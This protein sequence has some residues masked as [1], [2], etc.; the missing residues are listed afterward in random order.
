MLN[1]RFLKKTVPFLFFFILLLAS[2]CE[3][4]ARQAKKLMNEKRNKNLFLSISADVMSLDPRYGAD[5]TSS[6]VIKMLFE[7]LM[8][9]D[10]D[11]KVSPAIAESFEV[12]PD[13]KSYLFTLRECQWSNGIDVTAYDFE[14]AWKSVVDLNN[15][16]A[17]MAAHNFFILK[18]VLKYRSQECDLDQIGVRALDA[19]TLKVELE[20]P[21]PYFLEA[22]TNTWFFP[23]CKMVDQNAKIW[24]KEIGKG[25]VCN[26]PFQPVEHKLDYK[27]VM[28]KNP[29]F[30]DAC[31]VQLSKINIFIIKD[32]MTRFCLFEKG[33]IDWL[34]KPLSGLPLDACA[35]LRKEKKI[36]LSPSLG[37]YWY[38]FN[39]ERFPFTN[40]NMRKAFAFAVN[41]TEITEFMLQSDEE[42]A[43]SILPLAYGVNQKKYFDENS[44]SKAREYFDIGLIELGIKK[45]NLPELTISYNTDEIHQNVAQIIQQQIY[46]V[47]GVKL[48]LR[49]V[50]WRIHYANLIQGDF[51][52]GGMMWH[53]WIRD[54]I[55]ILQTFK[56]H[57][58]GINMARWYNEKF[59]QLLWLS[60]KEVNLSKRKKL[61]S[62]ALDVLME[63]MPV[64]PIYFTSIAYGKAE[65][66]KN[67]IVLENSMLDFRHAYFSE[68]EQTHPSN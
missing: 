59:K 66:L 45:E 44:L 38:F 40:K 61:L 21:I 49:H 26:G 27:I 6:Q 17:S 32:A 63:E 57:D 23:V 51:C 46:E 37:V 9:N 50:D 67:A 11:G 39:T 24:N 35:I 30:W 60:D 56:D 48:K 62:E 34:G 3:S 64:I 25:F 58:D 36:N 12:S 55:Y 52:I 8:Y 22:L 68:T 31:N 65:N 14:Y 42:P 47:L 2:S 43:D 29:L 1:Y 13:K 54:P 41:R 15:K 20:N 28:E 7:G 16:Q 33:R 18:N 53:S 5:G 19:R 10:S 4:A